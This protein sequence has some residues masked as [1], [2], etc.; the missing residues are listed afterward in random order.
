M[1]K[2]VKQEDRLA[3]ILGLRKDPLTDNIEL[4]WGHSTKN[5]CIGYKNFNSSPEAFMSE[6]PVDKTPGSAIISQSRIF[7]IKKK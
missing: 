2:N 3:G 7:K 4:F 1:I 5:M 6:L